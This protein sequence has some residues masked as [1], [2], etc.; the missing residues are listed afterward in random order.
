MPL[1][2]ASVSSGYIERLRKSLPRCSVFL[3][4]LNCLPL[5]FSNL[6][7]CWCLF[8]SSTQD[9]HLVQ[10]VLISMLLQFGRKTSL[11]MELSLLFVM[12]VY[13]YLSFKDSLFSTQGCINS[14]CDNWQRN[15]LF[16]GQAVKRNVTQ[17]VEFDRICRKMFCKFQ[18][19]FRF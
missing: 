17:Q 8:N 3:Q 1:K 5:L 16:R 14:A 10:L 15:F 4:S 11:G 12:M 6:S 9:K 2:N 18:K 7:T 13:C 19:R